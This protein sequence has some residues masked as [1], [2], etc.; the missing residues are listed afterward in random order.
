MNKEFEEQPDGS[1]LPK[2]T[3]EQ[4]QRIARAAWGVQH[5]LPH[6]DD[7]ADEDAAAVRE[8]QRALIDAPPLPPRGVRSC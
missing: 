2:Y 1:Q 3:E 4:A 7:V 5:L 8:F 6:A